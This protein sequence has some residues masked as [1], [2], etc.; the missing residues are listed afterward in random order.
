LQLETYLRAT[1]SHLPHGIIQSRNAAG[2][3]FFFI[4]WTSQTTPLATYWMANK[5]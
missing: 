1:E 2:L 4:D 3:S 5:I